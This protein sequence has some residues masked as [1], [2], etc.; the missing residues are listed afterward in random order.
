METTAPS[1]DLLPPTT[2]LSMSGRQPLSSKSR[3]FQRTPRHYQAPPVG[4][5]ELQ[6][7]T[8]APQR[9]G[10]SLVVLLLPVFGTVAG[11]GIALALGQGRFLLL[12]LPIMAFSY[13]AALYGFVNE[14]LRYRRERR[15]REAT[16]GEYLAR[17][18]VT[19][20]QLA[21]DQRGVLL[22]ANPDPEECERRAGRHDPERRLWERN[23]QDDDFLNLRLGRGPA[24][25]T[26]AIKAPAQSHLEADPLIER[27]GEL[28]TRFAS[29]HDAPILLSLSAVGIAALVGERRVQRD[30]VRAWLLQ[31][32]THHAPS[33][34]KIVLN[35]PDAERTEWEWARWLP[36]TW[37]DD[38]GQRYLADNPE[39]TSLCLGRIHDVLRQRRNQAQ[40]TPSSGPPRQTPTYVFVFAAPEYLVGPGA[41]SVAIP[42]QLLLSQGPALGA[43]AIFLEDHEGAVRAECRAIITAQADNAHLRL[44]GPPARELFYTPDAVAVGAADRLARTLA[45]LELETAA[46]TTLPNSLPFLALLGAAQV[47][48]LAVLTRWEAS[49]PFRTLATPIGARGGNETV[50]LDLH[51]N[52]HGPHGLVAGTT[53]SGKSELLQTLIVSLASNYHPHE[54][55]FVLIDYKGG[56]MAS[57]FRE[58]PHQIGIITNLEGSQALRALIALRS[59]MRRRQRL[60]DRHLADDRKHIDNYQELRRQRPEIAPLPRLVIIADEFAELKQTQ[61]EFMDELISIVRIGRSL[62]VHLILATQKPAGIVSDQIWSNTS[63]RIA[64]KVATTED[65]REVLK[66]PE[67]ADITRP[68]RAYLQVGNN[69]LFEL[70]QAGYSGAAYRPDEGRRRK[71][72]ISLVH[73]DGQRTLLWESTRFV[74]LSANRNQNQL[75]A[76][77]EHLR[78][79]AIQA[80]I[81][82]L[83][84]PWLPPLGAVLFLDDLPPFADRPGVATRWDDPPG[85]WLTPVIGLADDPAEQAQY[86]LTLNLGRD[87]HAVI[88][89]APG[90]G[91]TTLLQ[92][93]VI[94]LARS[95]TPEQVQFYILDF[96]ARVLR[97]LVD[98]PHVGAVVIPEE[99]ERLERL[100]RLLLDESERRKRLLE[101]LP[102]VG[103]LAAYRQQRRDAPPA[104]VL[105]IDNFAEFVGIFQDPSYR[106]P[107]HLE[108]ITRLSREGGNLG[109]HL[110]FTANS[111][112]GFPARILTNITAV[113]ALELT[114]ANEYANA[115]GRKGDDP[116]PLRGVRGRG[117]VRGERLLEFQ[118]ALPAA[119][120]TMTDRV[121]A[122][123]E[124][125]REIARGWTGERAAP[126]RT[127]PTVL[128]LDDLLPQPARLSGASQV[129]LAVPLA[130]DAETLEPIELPLTELPHFLIA[131]P[132]RCGK[133]TLLQTWALALAACYAPERVT[134]AIVSLGGGQFQAFRALPHTIAY[135]GDGQQAAQRAQQLAAELDARRRWLDE[136][137]RGGR[138]DAD[139]DG[140]LRQ[141]P[142][143]VLLID[144][145]DQFAAGAAGAAKDLLEAQIRRGPRLGLHTIVAGASAALRSAYGDNLAKFLRETKTGLLLGTTDN[146]DAEV[147]NLYLGNR[148]GSELPPGRGY[149]LRRGQPQLVQAATWHAGGGSLAERIAALGR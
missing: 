43:Y 79:A 2:T 33:E 20:R 118:A 91:K 122:L 41:T 96:G 111:T 109:L 31:I 90:T 103:N 86:S 97:L 6:A 30:Q 63:F 44:V 76:V 140:L 110:V 13:V 3:R 4:M 89:G 147:F 56:G 85:A 7:P 61:P 53:G 51:E 146:A 40:A 126:I 8:P 93:L 64:L 95:Y 19:F 68:G 57:A 125:I 22:A 32:A 130:R 70:F 71:D 138:F 47:G 99:T 77:I 9:P 18:E 72:T 28:A 94:A 113:L 36:H 112:Y 23:P 62:G 65:S 59:E 87:G 106:G 50:Y 119:G 60:F 128:P 129:A 127:L 102:G 143:I 16:Y 80:G 27:A 101:A 142:A 73:A 131:G 121:D 17:Q 69:E 114:E 136:A 84:G 35:Y 149:L 105:I 117:L 83:P 45:P 49:A 42:L 108:T 98:L 1:L 104:L 12:S 74:P 116:L 67:A 24:P 82:R 38:R 75:Q 123:R 14:R 145:Y 139:G 46:A 124:C 21:S 144:D 134:F 54:L 120:E 78:D 48:D 81:A 15:V 52:G 10:A 55:T 135:A 26:Y 37:S 132:P 39:A 5:Y 148:G 92:T 11:V 100:F 88:F 34:V 25:T 115:V 107:N 137:E 141:F 133:T 66:R 58:L 29:V